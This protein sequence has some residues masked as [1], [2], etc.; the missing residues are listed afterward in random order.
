MAGSHSN[1]RKRLRSISM[2]R[3]LAA[4]SGR[5]EATSLKGRQE[6]LMVKGGWMSRSFLCA[7]FLCCAV[8]L[9]WPATACEKKADSEQ[10]GAV[11]VAQESP[12]VSPPTTQSAEPASNPPVTNA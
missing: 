2:C 5:P 4:R 3:I 12:T 8:V 9:N 7:L 1:L 11:L 6:M 10:G